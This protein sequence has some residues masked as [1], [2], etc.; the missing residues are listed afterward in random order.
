MG[1]LL[2]VEKVKEDNLTW[3]LMGTKDKSQ[4][5]NSLRNNLEGYI[6]RNSK[7]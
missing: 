2:K 4:H 1:G 6:H 7:T 5:S 3:E